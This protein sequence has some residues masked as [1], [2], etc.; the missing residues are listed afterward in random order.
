VIIA[1][2]LA[3]ATTRAPNLRRVDLLEQVRAHDWY[4]TLELAPDVVTPGWF[5]TRAI[6]SKLPLPAS[7]HGKRCLDV[8]TFDGF[9]A[10]EMERRGAA[11]VIA[12]DVL[13]PAGWDWPAGSS[14]EV[15]AAL[16]ERKAR[17][18]GFEL[19]ARA[20]DSSVQRLERSVYELAPEVDG[21]FDFIY[22][23][24]LLLHLRDPVGA[25]SRVRAVCAGQLLL[26]DAIDPALTRRHPRRSLASLDARGRP[27]WW[28]PNL[29]GL[30]R[31]AE[32]AGFERAATAVRVAMPPGPGAQRAKLRPGLLLHRAGREALVRTRYGDPHAALLLSPV[33]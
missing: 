1:V 14:P 16:G 11:E 23:G 22:L 7:L 20:L 9:W 3:A 24:S 25:L 29:A 10:F 6:V 5:D 27:W 33:S 19:A 21:R 2:P 8:G 30:I 26:V 15:A 18:S 31:M 4:H 32:A 13:D 28:K 12:I 17:G